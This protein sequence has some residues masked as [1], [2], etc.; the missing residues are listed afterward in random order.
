MEEMIIQAG[1]IGIDY[2]KFQ[3]FK[4][5]NLNK[6]WPDFEKSY[7]YYKKVELQ[8]DDYSFIVEKCK[9]SGVKPLFTIFS[10]EL[11]LV[12]GV[13]GCDTVKIASPD[14][15]NDRLVD[16]CIQYFNHVIISTGM[17]DD[18]NIYKLSQYPNVS[19][20]Y[21]ISRYPAPKSEVDFDK[22]TLLGGF[23][24]HTPDIECAK[25]AI[26]QGV[27]WLERHYT[28]GKY[29]PGKDHLFSSTPDEFKEL[30]DYRNYLDKCQIYK[31][32]WMG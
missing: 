26:K 19:L 2:I 29:L 13:L 5:D 30:V 20:L 22:M 14:A 31:M 1:K 17:T 28:L 23:S 12:I 11:A 7:D 10:K 27:E 3:A 21:C 18:K 24:D 15:D 4:A 16:F 6:N 9:E 8:N 25:K 32:R